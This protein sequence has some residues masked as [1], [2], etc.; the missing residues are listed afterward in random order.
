M[1]A[2]KLYPFTVTFAIFTFKHDTTM[3]TNT[4]LPPM[5]T[6]ALFKIE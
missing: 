4:M 6:I 5:R 3:N 1:I 2:M